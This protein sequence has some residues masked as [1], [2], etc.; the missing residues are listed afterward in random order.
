MCFGK[1][2]QCFFFF[3]HLDVKN[4]FCWFKI[5]VG[6]SDSRIRKQPLFEIQ[7]ASIRFLLGLLLSFDVSL[8]LLKFGPGSFRN[9]E[10]QISI[11]LSC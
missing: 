8:H 7:E 2:F 1:L 4:S 3:F 9:Y 5:L 10:I 6:K 11:H